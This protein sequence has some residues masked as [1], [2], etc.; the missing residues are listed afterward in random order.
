MSSRDL[1]LGRTMWQIVKGTNLV[2]F[3]NGCRCRPM[4]KSLIGHH[5]PLIWTSS[6]ICGVRWRGQCRKPG[7]S[8]FPE[9]VMSSGPLCQTLV[10]KLLRLSLTFDHWLRPCKKNDISGRSTGVLHFLFKRSVFVNSPFKGQHLNS[11]F[12]NVSDTSRNKTPKLVHILQI[13]VYSKHVKVVAH[14]PHA[15]NETSRNK[16]RIRFKK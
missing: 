10:M 14:G 13:C 11:N 8:S 15:V 9:T 2:C 5:E 6:I 12:I 16:L 1:T 3:K 4:S 7:P